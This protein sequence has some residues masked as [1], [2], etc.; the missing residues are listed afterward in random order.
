MF[1]HLHSKCQLHR[2]SLSEMQPYSLANTP[3]GQQLS[4]ALVSSSQSQP[5]KRQ[6]QCACQEH[7][8]S[9]LFTEDLQLKAVY[10]WHVH[11]GP[12]L[13]AECGREGPGNSRRQFM[14]DHLG[15][16]IW[17]AII[18]VLQLV[19]LWT[20]TISDEHAALLI[21]VK[22]HHIGDQ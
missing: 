14:L 10:L 20:D 2:R 22:V 1:D 12:F 7:W 6:I 11:N 17:K 15:E 16:E 8:E 21:L 5:A 18:Y 13:E 4:E 3:A 19:Q 9:G